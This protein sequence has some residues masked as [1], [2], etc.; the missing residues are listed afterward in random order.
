M[1][2]ND[3]DNDNN[4]NNSNNNNDNTETQQQ[5]TK[6][7]KKKSNTMKI[8]KMKIGVSLDWLFATN[9]NALGGYPFGWKYFKKK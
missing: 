1:E 2:N 4:N 9:I 8:I 6:A 5:E 3:N 7:E